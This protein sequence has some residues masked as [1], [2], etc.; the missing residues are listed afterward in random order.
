MCEVMKCELSQRVM[1]DGAGEV[2]KTD[3]GGPI[4]PAKEAKE[5]GLYGQEDKDQ[6][7]DTDIQTHLGTITLT[8]MWRP[9]WK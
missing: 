5:S 7:N 2:S 4:H 1:G 6:L 3:Y 9:N 8:I